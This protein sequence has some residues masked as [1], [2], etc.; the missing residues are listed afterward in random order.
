V[1]SEEH[2]E[3][4][5]LALDF[6]RTMAD[7][8]RIRIAA[9][10]LQRDLSLEELA[11]TVRLSPAA[12]TR[13][14]GQLEALG[15]VAGVDR[16]D[17]TRL[18][19]DA[20][21]LNR[22]KREVLGG[23]RRKTEVEAGDDFARKVLRDFLVGERLK[24]IPAQP[25]KRAVVL[26]WLADQFTPGERYPERQVN[27]LLARHHPDFATLRRELVDSRLM[28]REAGV[29]WRSDAEPERAAST[30]QA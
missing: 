25:K 21:A 10:L 4:R 3:R 9:A 26:R 6:F 7:G 29:Y 30:D 5:E 13:H 15:L 20:D 28:R 23:S 8:D 17:G 2:D 11:E 19:F 14:L 27:E 24:T 18:R 1:D 12:V 16:P 22:L